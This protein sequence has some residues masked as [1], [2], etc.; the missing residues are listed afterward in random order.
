MEI[1]KKLEKS[2]LFQGIDVQFLS[3]ISKNTLIRNF[4]PGEFVF[5]E[6]DTGKYFYIVLEGRIELYKSSS[7]DR[8]IVLKTVGKEEIF[9]EVIIFEKN[10]YP[11]T[12]KATVKSRLLQIDKEI[13]IKLLN[14]EEFRIQ[15]IKTL[16]SKMRELAERL[17]FLNSM[18]VEE[19]FLF[20][21]SSNYGRQNSYKLNLSKK[22]VAR[23]IGTIPET[24]SRMLKKLGKEGIIWKGSSITV[25]ENF[26]KNK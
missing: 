11:A 18:D 23:E 5:F 12:A 3:Q 16:F 24:L 22:E 25:P 14:I 15:F 13:I 17:K 4:N 1:L 10:T 19:R 21:L 20:F 26:W 9:A 8:E 2:Y 7:D 6:G